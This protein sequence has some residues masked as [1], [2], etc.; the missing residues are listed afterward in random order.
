MFAPTS[1]EIAVRFDT[2]TDDNE[3]SRKASY[4]LR[5]HHDMSAVLNLLCWIIG[6]DPSALFTVTIERH[7]R[8][9]DLL[10]ALK[11]QQMRLH[12]VEQAKLK[13]WQVT[14]QFIITFELSLADLSRFLYIL[15][16]TNTNRKSRYSARKN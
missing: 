3:L 5:M 8:V 13:L 10:Q 15:R 4:L 1:L 12:D 6:E 16:M 9:A 11:E 14:F 7:K 2:A